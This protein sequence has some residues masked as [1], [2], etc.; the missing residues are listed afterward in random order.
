MFQ[1][2]LR[3]ICRCVSKHGF[4][5]FDFPFGLWKFLQN[6]DNLGFWKACCCFWWRSVHDSC[7]VAAA[8][9][10]K[11]SHLIGCMDTSS[12]WGSKLPFSF[13]FLS[14]LFK[15]ML[16][17]ILIMAE[18]LIDFKMCLEGNWIFL[19]VWRKPRTWSYCSLTAEWSGQTVW[20]HKHSECRSALRSSSSGFMLLVSVQPVL[21]A[22][23]L[24]QGLWFLYLPPHLQFNTTVGA[25]GGL[26]CSPERLTFKIITD[27]QQQSLSA[28]VFLFCFSA[29]ERFFLTGFFFN[30]SFWKPNV[31]LW[32]SAD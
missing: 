21:L 29:R 23:Q 28:F 14:F 7:C 31:F 22:G 20:D 17:K 10:F 9:W 27:R 11:W 4:T 18:Y 30:L 2:F 12:Q 3:T 15:T 8:V 1:A 25:G 6:Q 26:L 19:G 5:S 13:L 16:N 24:K 32:F